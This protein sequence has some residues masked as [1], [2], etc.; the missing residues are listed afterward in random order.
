MDADAPDFSSPK[1]VIDW[2]GG[3]CPVQ[4]EGTIEGKPFYF[5]SRGAHW[6]LEVGE[7]ST[8]IFYALTGLIEELEGAPAADDEAEAG[9]AE[10]EP[11][12]RYEEAY[13]VWPDAGYITDEEARTFITKGAQIYASYRRER[14][15]PEGGADGE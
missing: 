11:I 15:H 10:N 3:M 12:W 5:R 4:A 2:L 13:G 7:P 14:A 1:I 8:R 9:A 6:S